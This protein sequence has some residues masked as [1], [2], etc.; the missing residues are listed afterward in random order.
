MN[1]LRS[2]AVAALLLA[3]AGCS[4]GSSTP[5]PSR[6][7]FAPRFMSPAA[8]T[9]LGPAFDD[10]VAVLTSV[11]TGPSPG[12]DGHEPAW[13]DCGN[14]PI[15]THAGEVLVL[16]NLR[17]IDGVG[18]VIALSSPCYVRSSDNLPYVGFLDVDSADASSLAPGQLRSVVLHELLHVMGFGTLWNQ[19]GL[20]PRIE[21]SGTSDPSFNGSNAR[22]AFHDFD[23]V[24]Y[25]GTAVPVENTGAPA[26]RE[27]HWRGTV[28][29]TELMTAYLGATSPL[30]RTTIE[31]LA[32]LGWK[33]NPASADP[34]QITTTNP[35]ALMFTPALLLDVG[36]DALPI[37][38][39]SR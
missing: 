32:D 8:E 17:P 23:G 34:F 3:L 39:R 2:L 1:P 18:G 35:A 5:A 28:F 24:G 36:E 9:A 22:A 37:V 30:S 25:L 20:P 38:P 13:A 12:L 14:I 33:V 15:T 6:R 29:G 26:S 10:A 31:S 16:V 11:I 4:G 27:K 21:G 7:F 19:P